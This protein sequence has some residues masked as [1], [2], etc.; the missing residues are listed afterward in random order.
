MLVRVGPATAHSFMVR[1]LYMQMASMLEDVFSH[2]MTVLGVQFEV[3]PDVIAEL[4]E[5]TRIPKAFA[6]VEQT[7]DIG[8]FA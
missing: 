4:L 3:S 7:Y 8:T 1:E 5:I 2:T 6:K